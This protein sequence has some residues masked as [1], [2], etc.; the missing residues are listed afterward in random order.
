MTLDRYGLA[1]SGAPEAVA[2]LDLAFTLLARFRPAVVD[3]VGEALRLDPDCP[4]ARALRA[5]LGLMSSEAPEAR[6]AARLAEG[7]WGRDDRERGHFAAIRAWGGGDWSRAARI[8]DGILDDHPTDFLA[9]YVGHQLDF[10]LGDGVNLPGRIGRVLPRWDFAHPD[11]GYL[12]GMLAFGLEEAG[13]YGRAEA[14]AHAA[15]DAHADD[16]WAIHALAHVHEM[17]G[18]AE[19]GL[20]MLE[21]RRA[22]WDTDNF[23][24]VHTA[25]HGAIFALERGEILQAL[26]AY[27]AVIQPP[28]SDDVAM[29]ML[30]GA[31]LL[32]RLHLDGADVGDRWRPLADAWAGKEP[33]PWY[34]FNDLHAIMTFVG[35]GR[36]AEAEARLEVLEGFARDGDPALTNHAMVTAAGLPVARAL[37]SFGK[38][39]MA[40]AVTDLAR[41]RLHLAIF[42][43]SHAQRDAFQRTLLV[44]A[45]RAGETTFARQ[46]ARERLDV[47]PSSAWAKARLAE[48]KA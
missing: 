34:V 30:D 7:D 44:A 17:R 33:T 42:G 24:R 41:V 25:W 23:L 6:R 47:R 2:A 40:A 39:A 27:D 35:A 16:V 9:L 31:S 11:R 22:D 43:G 45:H 37:L 12:C 26:A 38:G 32:W 4:M 48:A 5:Y 46:L 21:A 1:V 3:H 10:F 13:D 20:A 8:L 28:D 36:M 18:E 14:A 15:L 29:E 19:A